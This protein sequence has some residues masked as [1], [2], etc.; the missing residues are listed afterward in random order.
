[1]KYRQIAAFPFEG[2]LK[3]VTKATM[4]IFFI[5]ELLYG[6]RIC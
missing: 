2:K 5:E 3:L 4:P 6:D 1:M